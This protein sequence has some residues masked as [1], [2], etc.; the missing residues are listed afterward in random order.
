MW[1]KWGMKINYAELCPGIIPSGTEQASRADVEV[2]GYVGGV[3]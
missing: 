2:A 3:C 1:N